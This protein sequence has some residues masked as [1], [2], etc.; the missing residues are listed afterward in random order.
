MTEKSKTRI[1][2]VVEDDP[3]ISSQMGGMITAKG[4]RPLFAS[5]AEE[6]IGIAEQDR[7]AMVLT[8]VQLP[9][10]DTLLHLLSKHKT[11][12]DMTVAIIDLDQPDLSHLTLRQN[13]RILIDFD[14]LDDFVRG[15]E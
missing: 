13:L 1:I 10:L 8:D 7:P 15:L 5:S 9:T 14:H 4:H 12:Q 3:E 2:I 11:L 6:A